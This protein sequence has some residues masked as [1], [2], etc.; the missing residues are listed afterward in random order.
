MTRRIRTSIFLCATL[1]AVRAPAQ[2]SPARDR[3]PGRERDFT[4]LPNGWR[5]APAGRHLAVGDLPLSVLQSPDGCCAIVSTGGFD[6]PTL[7]VVDLERM[8]VRQSFEPGNA[9]LGLAWSADGKR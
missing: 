6:T 9:W 4:L 3:Q 1:L 7:T 2:E 5:I 8:Q